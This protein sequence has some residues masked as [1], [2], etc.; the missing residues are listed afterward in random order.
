M[1]QGLARAMARQEARPPNF[2]QLPFEEGMI[3]IARGDPKHHE[4]VLINI[5]RPPC[6]ASGGNQHSNV[7]ERKPTLI[8]LQRARATCLSP[9]GASKRLRWVTDLFGLNEEEREEYV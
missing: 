7:K 2:S 9:M 8:S 5:F 4:K 1:G 6:E 3:F